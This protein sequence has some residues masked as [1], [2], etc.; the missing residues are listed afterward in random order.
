MPSAE[1]MQ[2]RDLIYELESRWISLLRWMSDV[3]GQSPESIV[4]TLGPDGLRA[5]EHFDAERRRSPGANF[6][7]LHFL[8]FPSYVRLADINQ[9]DLAKLGTPAPGWTKSLN[10]QNQDLVRYRNAIQH[11][12]RFDQLRP[13]D[14][15]AAV[16]LIEEQLQH[17]KD[18]WPEHPYQ[19]FK[20]LLEENDFVTGLQTL[21]RDERSAE[22]LVRELGFEA[23]KSPIDLVGPGETSQ[24]ASELRAD[25]HR[26]FRVGQKTLGGGTVAIF[27]A[28]LN[29]WPERSADRERYRRRLARAI[30]LYGQNDARFLVIMMDGNEPLSDAAATDEIEIVYP[31]QRAG[32]PFGTV[33]AV[34]DRL[35]PTRYH[36]DLLQELAITG[37]N[38]VPEVARRWNFAFD[39]ERV[40]K[41]FYEEFRGLRDRIAV[42]FVTQNSGN[43]AFDGMGLTDFTAGRGDASEAQQRFQQHVLAFATR[44]LSRILF[45]WFL[46]Q[47]GWLGSDALGETKTLLVDMFRH[48]PEGDDT[49]F[50]DVL[51]PLFFDGVGTPLN[52]AR[53]EAVQDA[54]TDLLGLQPVALP[55]LG[56]SLFRADADPFERAV[57]GVEDG[58]RTIDVSL[59]DVLFDPARDNRDRP[60]RG[61][62]QGRQRSVLG[63]LQ[64][65]RFT[66]Q[67]SSPDDLSVDPDPELLGK[68]FE[69]LYQGDERHDTGAYYT[70]REVVRYT[71]RRTLDGYLRDRTG[72]DQDTLDWLRD[73]AVDWEA[74]AGR[75][76]LA[77]QSALEEALEEVTVVDPAVGSGAF[78]VGMLQEIVLLRRGI[79]TA[80]TDSQVARGGHDVFE[81]KRRAITHSLHGVDINSTAV[82]ICR[83]R[84]WLSLVIDYA[85]QY[86]SD[87]TPLPNLELGV[88]AGDSL[89]DRMGSEPL[90]FSLP[91]THR[92][93]HFDTQADYAR[94][95]DLQERYEALNA[96]EHLTSGDVKRLRHI[97][98][99]IHAQ[100]LKL[101]R[102]DVSLVIEAVQAKR[103]KLEKEPKSR[104]K[105]IAAA[106]LELVT[107]QALDAGL[108]PDAPYMKPFLWPLAFPLMEE[109]GGF[110]IV[111]ANPPYIRQESL[112]AT[113]QKAYE[114]AFPE[115]VT[116]TTDILVPFYARGT[117]LLRS[118]GWLAF[119][120]SN[121]YMRA[122]YGE[123][124]RG[125]LPRALQIEEVIDF[126]DLPVFDAAAYPAV[127]VGQKAVD[128]EPE[129][130]LAAADLNLPIR[131]RIL[132]DGRSV[133]VDGVRNELDGLPELIAA[134]R[135]PGFTQSLLRPSRWILEPPTLVR[136][137]ERLMN[138]Y[139][140]LKEVVNGR[141]YYGIKTGLNEAFVIDEAT[142][143]RL[144]DEDERSTELIRPWLR[145][146]DIKR[147]QADWKRLFVIFA[148][149]GTQLDDY[150]AIC[151]HLMHWHEELE[152]RKRGD[153]AKK[154]G[155]KPGDYKWFEIQDTVAYH[156]E[157]QE[158]KVILT[159][160]L[161]WSAFSYDE[162]GFLHN[163]AATFFV[164]PRPA[165]TAL[166]N[167]NLGWF[168]LSTMGT[169]LQNG[170]V[171]L[172][173]QFFEEFPVPMSVL[174][175][176]QDARR[177][178]EIV[179]ALALGE[180]K[181]ESEI[182]HLVASFYDLTSEETQLLEEWVARNRILT[183]NGA[184]QPATAER[185]REPPVAQ[186]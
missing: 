88:L 160:F 107:L 48:R 27:L 154:K 65:Y 112:S 184:T 75:L 93:R 7:E 14:R 98:S 155:R 79:A 8:N 162:D 129:R 77:Q 9:S 108:R 168:I 13:R 57:F 127:V 74:G 136:L 60:A 36:R 5:I 118:G 114:A 100:R 62:G 167:S 109:R 178:D 144:I 158:P 169:R 38:S 139:E 121:K 43:P 18:W 4:V 35:S 81:W 49:Y 135:A 31:R 15:R 175:V 132:D 145:G 151:E 115:V 185:E 11:A 183:T 47:K 85:P 80:R 59:P 138:E 165:L 10:R 83:L 103:R 76:T 22:P 52:D 181:D 29:E 106:E 161:N 51:A 39:V 91:L 97:A 3:T 125:F 25:I 113:D 66:T 89:V 86:L 20:P 84:L 78:L 21:S 153:G 171:Q 50:R 164:S 17:L 70:P 124:L 94:L 173:V 82:E 101:A 96:K 6:N 73:E 37:L 54:F 120:T 119:I 149:R 186:N 26:L 172:F 63:M 137:F 126:G 150:P 58:Q 110:D 148:R 128:P 170:Y 182:D 156:R 69:N 87:I 146:Q 46:Q 61:R 104:P 142:K 40:T 95:R 33:R 143:V 71:C 64:S 117:Q 140:N 67:E 28:Y 174:D 147:W 90:V 180:T 53:H 68:V 34:I 133:N 55:F 141:I 56:G 134:N 176:S 30:T 32:R 159:H 45:L 166:L 152:P 105:A 99:D 92:Q 102:A 122:A 23:V 12:T 2:A 163:N 16:Q 157:F 72:L 116:G 179:G 42:A 131:R 177:L 44:Q 130:E 123:K 19:D 111:V 41:T 1:Y 24:L